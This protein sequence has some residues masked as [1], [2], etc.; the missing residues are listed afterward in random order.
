MGEATS[1]TSGDLFSDLGR[2]IGVAL[3]G[4]KFGDVGVGRTGVSFEMGVS[5]GVGVLRVGVD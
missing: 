3:G 4:G 1:V 5:I 2:V